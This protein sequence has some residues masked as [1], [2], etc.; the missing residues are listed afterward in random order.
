MHLALSITGLDE[1][2]ALWARAPEVVERHLRA[3]MTE[4]ELLLQ[5]E[6]VDATPTGA[7]Q[8]LRKSI[9]AESPVSTVDGLIG[10]V[11]VA[12]VQGRYG[13]VLNYAAAVELG[14]K[15]HFPPLEPLADWAVAKLGVDKSAAEEVAMAIARKISHHGTEGA[16]MF[17]DTARAQEGQVNAMFERAMDAAVAEL[18]G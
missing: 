16:F 3:A 15:P 4:A 12:D 2:A 10:V 8:L 1:I 6:V 13:S 11:D 9:T 5:R 18:G 14:T 17:R 7:N